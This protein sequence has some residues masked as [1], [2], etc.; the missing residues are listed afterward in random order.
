MGAARAMGNSL[1]R[2]PIPELM[3]A[4]Q[5]NEDQRVKG[6][7]AW[8]LGKWGERKAR[9]AWGRFLPGS[10]GLAKKDIEDALAL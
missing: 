6:M 3:R 8:D 9:S 4:F 10:A 1:K 5:E 2:D 7:I